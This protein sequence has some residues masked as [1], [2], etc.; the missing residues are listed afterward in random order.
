MAEAGFGL[1]GIDAVVV[2]EQPRIAPLADAMRETIADLLSVP[3][4]RVSVKGKTTEGMGFEGT[5]EGI[6]AWAVALLRGGRKG[7]E[8]GATG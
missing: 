2:C 7:S 5:G 1:L 4:D 6:S 3:A 8:G